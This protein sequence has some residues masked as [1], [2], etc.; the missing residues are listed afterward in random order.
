MIGIFITQFQNLNYQR[1]SM[2]VYVYPKTALILEYMSSADMGYDSLRK[3]AKSTDCF[4]CDSLKGM[5]TE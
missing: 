5:K 2:S 4:L 3:Y 1:Y